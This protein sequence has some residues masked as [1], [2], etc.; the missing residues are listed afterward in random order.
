MP[1]SKE[2][3]V[4]HAEYQLRERLQS[5]TIMFSVPN[6]SGAVKESLGSTATREAAPEFSEVL[7]FLLIAANNER[8]G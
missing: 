4:L 1:T 5:A 6:R 7:T 3:L 8:V 2:R